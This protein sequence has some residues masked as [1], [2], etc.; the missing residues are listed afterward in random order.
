ML[1]RIGVGG[2]GVVLKGEHTCL[3]RLVAIKVLSLP[4]DE[5]NT[6]LLTRFYSEMRTVA[7]LQHP[8]IVAALD[9]G[10]IVSA[11]PDAPVLHYFVM[12]YEDGKDLEDYVLE[13]GPLPVGRACELIYQLASALDEAHKHHLV[14]RDIKPPNVLLTTAGQA[15]LLDFGLARHFRNRMTEPGTL[16][17]TIEYMAPEQAR[18]AR[19]VDIRA[20][21]YSLGGTL[22]WCLSGRLPFPSRGNITE[23]LIERLTQPAPSVRLFRPDIPPELDALIARMMA[24]NPDDRL[25]N[26]QAVMRALLPFLH[27]QPQTLTGASPP[28]LKPANTTAAMSGKRVHRVLIVDDEV[29]IGT[30]CQAL[31]TAPDLECTTVTSGPE[32]M[33]LLAGQPFDLVLLDNDMPKM[34]GVEVVRRLRRAAMFQSQN[35][36]V[37]RSDEP[38]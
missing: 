13:E 30:I 14:H 22:F 4:P 24:L 32:A 9:A 15:K 23:D 28:A 3:R 18:D 31:L 10:K 20:D 12:A 35:R 34:S 5:D 11:D 27:A 21:I 6:C 2:M 19:N 29:D 17:G 33:G 7:Q 16:L 1:D 26:P 37:L 38:G 25:P 8:N 36:H